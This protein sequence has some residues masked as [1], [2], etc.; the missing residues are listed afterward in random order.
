MLDEKL[1]SL[2]RHLNYRYKNITVAFSIDSAKKL[3]YFHQAVANSNE[4]PTYPFMLF[5]LELDYRPT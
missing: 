4:R 2:H 1:I 5:I 3:A